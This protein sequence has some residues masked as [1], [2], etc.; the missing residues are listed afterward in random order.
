MAAFDRVRDKWESISPRERRMVVLLGVSFVV[1]M[2]L[3][4][5]LAIKDELDAL[6]AK[7]TKART[8]LHKLTAYRASAK[9]SPANDP[10]V[11][12][13]AEPVKLESY[14]FEAGGTAKITIPGVTPRSPITRG[15]FTVHAAVVDVRD[16]TLAQVTEFLAALEGNSRAVA[17]TSLTIKRNFRDPEK[18]DLSVEVS[19]YSRAAEATGDGAGSGSGSGSAQAGG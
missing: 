10:T 11:F 18:M 9:P 8:A 6:E 13:G 4:V 7:N 19:A 17:V 16:L 12:I 2:V 5:A 14:I 15:R 1:I 3:Y